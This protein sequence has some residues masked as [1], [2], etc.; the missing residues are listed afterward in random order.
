MEGSIHFAKTLLKLPKGRFDASQFALLDELEK[1]LNQADRI[2][3]GFDGNIGLE[4]AEYFRWQ[5]EQDLLKLVKSYAGAIEID[6]RPGAEV[7]VPEISV[8]LTPGNQTVMLK[9][10]T[11]REEISFDSHKWNLSAEQIPKPFRITVADHQVRY[12]M[13]A[14]EQVPS[15]GGLMHVHFQGEG[16]GA[17]SQVRALKFE[18]PRRGHL[19]LQITDQKGKTTPAIVQ[20]ADRETG[21]LLDLPGAVDLREQLNHV[22]PHIGEAGRG[23]HFFL[24]GKQRGRYWIVDGQLELALPV[25]KW[26]LTVLHGPEHIPYQQTFEIAADQR[27]SHTCQLKRWIYMPERGWYSG[28]D[29]VHARLMHGADAENLLTYAQAVDVHI[30]NILE[31]GDPMRTYYAQRGFGTDFRSQAGNHW[32]VPGQED[33]RSELGHAIGLNLKSKV[34]DLDRYM[35]NDWI[36]AE[37]HKQGGLYGH[38][39]VGANAC[40]AHRE[41]ALFT[42][43]GIVDFNSIMQASLGTELYYNFLNLG[44]QMNASAGADTPYGGTIGAT[45]VY[46]E[47]GERILT[48]DA[49]FEALQRGQ[50]FVTNGPMLEFS[51]A[52]QPPG[53]VIEVN[54]PRKLSVQAVARGLAGW[55]APKKLQL[56][57]FGKVVAEVE[58]SNTSQEELELKHEFET[59]HGSWLALKA[60]GHDGSEAH[61]TPVYVKRPNFRHWHYVRA[62]ELI[63]KQVAVLD[64]IEAT[65]RKSE[66][67]VATEN[68]PVDYWNRGIAKEADA[69]RKQVAK[70]RAFYEAL[71][72]AHHQEQAPRAN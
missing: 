9:V 22:V 47:T 54:E 33:P 66:E 18:V 58:S 36:A 25:G 5:A 37:I 26:D 65:L 50:S 28:D 71:R 46:V 34:R 64:E 23:Y 51:V 72:V 15:E 17:V 41:M 62:I 67:R 10:V 52:G 3:W 21:H 8:Q 12:V 38:T 59:E 42:P 29:H 57:R 70:A 63:S 48:P 4:V 16:P 43:L 68:N 6:L 19:R 2:R 7:S 14:F 44:F 1:K 69:V 49:W 55:S 30:A 11:G 20:L 60:E 24:P 13:I 40:F 45:R 39:H 61:T 31:M 53:S 32:L 35:Q 27:V 56:I